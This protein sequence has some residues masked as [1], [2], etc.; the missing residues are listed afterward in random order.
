MRAVGVGHRAAGAS[1]L[2]L[3]AKDWLENN[4]NSTVDGFNAAWSA[5]D[6]TAKKVYEDRSVEAK[7]QQKADNTAKRKAQRAAKNPKPAVD[8]GAARST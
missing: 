6:D 8:T 1:S 5:L 4:L 7:T 3:F 2:S